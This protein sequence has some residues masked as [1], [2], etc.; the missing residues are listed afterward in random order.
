MA[1]HWK[2]RQDRNLRL[3]ISWKLPLLSSVDSGNLGSTKVVTWW[4]SPKKSFQ[5]GSVARRGKN[6][7]YP[8]YTSR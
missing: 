4:N 5:N 2:H 7:G 8:A 6:Q 3:D 1:A